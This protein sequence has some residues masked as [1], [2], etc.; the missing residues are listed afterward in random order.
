MRSSPTTSVS[1]AR[2]ASFST[3]SSGSIATGDFN[4]TTLAWHDIN[5]R[6]YDDSVVTIGTQ[7]QQA[8]YKGSPSNGDFRITHVFVRD[9][10]SWKI[11]SMQLSLTGPPP[12]LTQQ[13]DPPS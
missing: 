2:S 7:S 5:V 8:S 1:S 10:N 9:G 4:T 6:E 11:A 13:E 3:S 12:A